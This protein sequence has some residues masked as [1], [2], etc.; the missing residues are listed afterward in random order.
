M[1][2]EVF[3]AVPLPDHDSAE[4]TQRKQGHGPRG[5]PAITTG[6][7]R[8]A[9][10][11]PSVGAV[12]RVADVVWTARMITPAVDLVAPVFRR[13]IALDDGHGVVTS[14]VLHVSSLGVHECSIDGVPVSPEVLSPGWSAYEW[15]LRYRSHDVTSLLRDASSA[16]C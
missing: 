5:I 13:E 1:S 9:S 11:A 16:G 2:D 7:F 6:W 3:I 4:V 8:P 14:A 15:R 10:A 12:S